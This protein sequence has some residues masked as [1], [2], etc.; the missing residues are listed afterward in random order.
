MADANEAADYLRDAKARLTV[1]R[2]TQCSVRFGQ[3]AAVVVE[4]AR[5]YRA[6]LIALSTQGRS[7]LDRWLFGN[8]ITTIA[9]SCAPLL[10]LGPAFRG[11]GCPSPPVGS[12]AAPHF[13][14]RPGL[15]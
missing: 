15:S 3:P 14:G 7:C 1:G 8:M 11:F 9:A 12:E 10:L 6:G 2:S 4:A 13:A 5:E